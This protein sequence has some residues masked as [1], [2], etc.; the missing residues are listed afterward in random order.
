MLRP[1]PL[2]FTSTLYVRGGDLLQ[3]SFFLPAFAQGCFSL[4]VT[5]FAEPAAHENLVSLL[6]VSDLQNC[7]YCLYN[8][9]GMFFYAKL[10]LMNS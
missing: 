2:A 1:V 5:V 3:T 9:F 6:Y 7:L 4:Q 8:P 10:G